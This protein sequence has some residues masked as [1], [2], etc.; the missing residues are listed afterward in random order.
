MTWFRV[1]DN[2][3]GHKKARRAGLSAMGLWAV[4]GSYSSQQRI[5]GFVPDW[6]VTTWPSGKSLAGKLVAAGLW[7]PTEQDGDSG[8]RFH[9][10]EHCNPS[11]ETIE[12]ERESARQRMAATRAAK[13]ASG[14]VEQ[15]AASSEDVPA[16]TDRTEGARS[17][18][19]R[20]RAHGPAL[21]SPSVVLSE[22]QTPP[23]GAAD[24]P[25]PCPVDA[26]FDRFWTAYPRREAKEAA[27]RA[28]TKARRKT[29]TEQIITG[30]A[31][32]RDDPNRVAEFT[33][34]PSTW[35]NAGSWDDEPLP[36]RGGLSA[37]APVDPRKEWLQG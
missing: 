15:E 4:A 24:P 27:R 37:V 17:G 23:A 26:L 31:R 34:H 19:P 9:D 32:F 7:V 33:P 12:Q 25:T 10:W 1:D 22:L 35:L 30:A 5:G 11:K 18:T 2:L 20:G 3:C 16:N 36:R 13:K 14:S 29:D 8:W 28:F 21:P 6:Y